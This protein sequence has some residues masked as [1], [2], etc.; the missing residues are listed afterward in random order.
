MV[1][2]GAEGFDMAGRGVSLVLRASWF[3]RSSWILAK[4][5]AAIRVHVSQQLWELLGKVEAAEMATGQQ[6]RSSD[7]R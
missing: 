3:N 5:I 7:T 2:E 4:E 1:V 6:E